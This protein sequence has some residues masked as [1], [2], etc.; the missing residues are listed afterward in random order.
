MSELEEFTTHHDPFLIAERQAV[1]RLIVNEPN[2]G[3]PL[4]DKPSPYRYTSALEELKTEMLVESAETGQPS[5]ESSV[6]ALIHPESIVVS[7]VLAAVENSRSG[8]NNSA[9]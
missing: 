8:S 7:A 3:L 1:Q 9:A 6:S 4:A 5:A 2:R